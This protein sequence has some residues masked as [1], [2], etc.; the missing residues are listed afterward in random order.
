MS[1]GHPAGKLKSHVDRIA[2]R[3]AG[4]RAVSTRLCR[5]G[6]RFRHRHRIARGGGTPIDTK[7]EARAI[8]AR[9]H[10]EPFILVTSAY[11]GHARCRSW[12]ARGASYSCTDGS[13]DRYWRGPLP[14]S[15]GLY[16]TES[17]VHAYLGFASLILGIE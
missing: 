17:A 2:W 9:Q 3:A 11:P 14:T 12:N 13:T 15:D 4:T 5:V 8:G 10:L 6:A 16:N 1:H 7:A